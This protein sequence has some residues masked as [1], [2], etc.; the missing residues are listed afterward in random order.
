M[1][2]EVIFR[3][4]QLLDLVR[5]LDHRL[6]RFQ[7]LWIQLQFVDSPCFFYLRRRLVLIRLI[8]LIFLFS[9]SRQRIV[10]R[11][12]EQRLQQLRLVRALVK[13]S[14]PVSVLR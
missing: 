4:H 6:R 10:L 14:T 12:Q 1:L 7:H 5:L 11:L 8:R 13:L 2:M 3:R 9:F